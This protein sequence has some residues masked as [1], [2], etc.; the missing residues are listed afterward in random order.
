MSGNTA[1]VL[2][3]I[4]DIQMRDVESPVLQEGQ[5]LIEM[6]SVGICGSDVHYWKHGRIGHFVCNGPMV[7]GHECAGIVAEV[8]P[9]CT[10]LQKGDRVA[11]EAGL[12]CEKCDICATG[13]YNLCPDMRFFATPPVHGAL[14]KYLA[15]PEKWCFKIPDNMTLEEGA[16][17]EPLSV[18]VYA[19]EQKARVGPGK[20]VAIFGAGPIGML[21]S[22]VA[23]GLGAKRIFLCDIQQGRLDTCKK[24]LGDVLVPINTEGLSGE[25]VANRVKEANE[26][27]LVDGSIDCAGVESVVQAAILSTKNGGAVCLVGMGKPLCNIPLLDASIREVD[28]MGVFRYR[29]T[30]PTCIDLLSKKKIDVGPLITHRFD[31]TPESINDAF[32]T[33]R[34]GRDG[35]IKCMINLP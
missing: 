29:N 32:E 26:G 13:K 2:E 18:G 3:K 15:H 1:V 25:D 19:C 17:C 35:A 28:L 27:E 14:V 9:G 34:T 33:C 16:M 23:N 21:T 24:L 22:L 5:V 31:Y 4:D 11:L 10:T 6:K 12:P 8:G 7:L 30:Y 20:T